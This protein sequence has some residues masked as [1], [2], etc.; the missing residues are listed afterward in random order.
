[1]QYILLS[2]T[3]PECQRVIC[4]TVHQII[5]VSKGKEKESQLTMSKPHS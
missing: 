4:T 1:M 2:D 5:S 3:K